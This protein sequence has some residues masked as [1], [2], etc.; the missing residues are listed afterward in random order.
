MEGMVEGKHC[1]CSAT[2][3]PFQKGLNC[4]ILTYSTQV[5][6]LISS[7]RATFLDRWQW[8]A[9]PS[10]LVICLFLQGCF[11]LAPPITRTTK[12]LG[13]HLTSICFPL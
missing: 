2:F 6:L 8:P 7:L 1:V 13:G 11:L 9:W 3:H 4:L 10:S 12:H 5:S